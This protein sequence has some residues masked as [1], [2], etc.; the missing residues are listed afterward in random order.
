MPQQPP[1][2]KDPMDAWR[3]YLTQAER[4][5]N[6][7][8]N[9]AMGS[10]AFSQVMGTWMSSFLA[11]Q[12][13]VGETVEKYLTSFNLP[14]RSDI[15]DLGERLTR[16]EDR[17]RRIETTVTPSEPSSRRPTPPRTRKPPTAATKVNAKAAEKPVKKAAKKTA[18]KKVAKKKAAKTS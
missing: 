15:T 13:N 3:Q 5:W 12:K 1:E 7:Y 6:Q 9:Q 17:L 14:S 8:L 11:M 16:I 4:E 2:I 18:K 10:D